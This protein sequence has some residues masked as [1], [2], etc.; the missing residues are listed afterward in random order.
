P[1][2][3]LGLISIT[4][5]ISSMIYSKLFPKRISVSMSVILS[6]ISITFFLLKCVISLL[7]LLLFSQPHHKKRIK[8]AMK[9]EF[10]KEN[11]VLNFS[12]FQILS[13]L[14]KGLFSKRELKSA[15]QDLLFR[16]FV[17]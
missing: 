2:S 8:I 3:E 12:F 16:T 11:I 14:N 15:K 10:L 17:V 7:S 5:S 13:T 6:L 9:L 4:I 1:L